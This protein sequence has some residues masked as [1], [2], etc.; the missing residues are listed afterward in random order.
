MY[1]LKHDGL[2][3]LRLETIEV[4]DPSIAKRGQ[5]RSTRGLLISWPNYTMPRCACIGLRTYRMDIT[6]KEFFK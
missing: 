4:Y 2:D 3:G 5:F 6:S 1:S